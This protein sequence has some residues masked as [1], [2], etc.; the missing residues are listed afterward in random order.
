[1]VV[2]RFW[3]GL[4]LGFVVW[5]LVILVVDEGGWYFVFLDCLV[6][7]I[8]LLEVDGRG[9]REGRFGGKGW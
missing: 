6:D 7:V 8:G 2:G 3:W 4:F 1:M 5:V 9:R